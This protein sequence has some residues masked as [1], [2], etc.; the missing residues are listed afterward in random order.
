M[1]PSSRIFG[2]FIKY[3]NWRPIPRNFSN[4]EGTPN[5][6]WSY[7]SLLASPKNR[8]VCIDKGKLSGVC[9]PSSRCHE[10]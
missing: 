1:P 10:T 4:K 8:T 5:H 9:L 3:S 7:H 2:C 6:R